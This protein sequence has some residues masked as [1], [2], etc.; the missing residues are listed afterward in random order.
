MTREREA[1]AVL[2]VR[3]SRLIGRVA[4]AATILL[5]VL[6]VSAWPAAAAES[7]AIVA[8]IESRQQKAELLSR[9]RAAGYDVA[10]LDKSVLDIAAGLLADIERGDIGETD[11]Q[12]P[13]HLADFSRTV[14]AAVPGLPGYKRVHVV[15]SAMLP[16]E[17]VLDGSGGFMGDSI[18]ISHEFPDARRPLPVPRAEQRPFA[19]YVIEAVMGMPAGSVRA[20]QDIVQVALSLEGT[21]TVELHFGSGRKSL[22]RTL[23]RDDVGILHIDTHGSEGGD[24]IQVSRAGAMLPARA[25]PQRVRVPVVLLFG[26][27]GVANAEA[28]G[29]VLRQRGAEAVIS[30]FAKFE[31][32]GLTGDAT[33]EKRIYEAFFRSIGAGEDVGTALLRL[34]QVARAEA[35]SAGSGRTLTRLFFVLLGNSRLTLSGPVAAN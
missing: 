18:V 31:S 24:A 27:E 32:F 5:A 3:H 25:L 15:S 19:S 20:E 14:L 13:P 6:A 16:V 11:A 9:L 22:E 34:R 35:I 10:V 26:C 30:S 1:S 2:L 8:G 28:F 23:L 12:R 4:I 21:Y 7:L 33:R 29:A 17:L